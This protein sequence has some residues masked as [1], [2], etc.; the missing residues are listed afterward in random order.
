MY[1]TKVLNYLISNYLEP[2][3]DFDELKIEK[4]SELGFIRYMGSEESDGKVSYL[5]N[6]YNGNKKLV[7]INS[8]EMFVKYR[9]HK[10]ELEYFNPFVKYKNALYLLLL[11][12]PVL[13][14]RYSKCVEDYNE[15]DLADMIVNDELNVTQDEIIK[16]VN[17]K[18]Y[19]VKDEIYTY[20]VL[21]NREDG[22][23]KKFTS[24]DSDKIVAILMLILQIVS[25]IDVPPKIFINFNKNWDQVKLDL[26]E[27]LE[28]Y[29]KERELNRKDLQKNK[30]E[31]KANVDYS[32]NAESTDDDIELN[33]IEELLSEGPE[34]NEEVKEDKYV[35]KEG[36]IDISKYLSDTVSIKPK[37]SDQD[38]FGLEFV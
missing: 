8:A 3:L 17:I 22:E 4:N 21:L 15:E 5:E 1:R 27:Q 34:N 25:D 13:F 30:V 7:L 11:A 33:D 24:S 20:E 12:T 16:Y 35:S 28:L 36:T 19:P 9:I 31:D 10:D 29:T 38:F 18:Q 26:K 23:T 6:E 14:T 37:E 2:I 32:T